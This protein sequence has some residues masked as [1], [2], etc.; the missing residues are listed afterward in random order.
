MPLIA[1]SG[2]RLI[3]A[4]GNRSLLR[5]AALPQRN[6][7]KDFLRIALVNNMP[8]AAL[9]DT[10]LQFFELLS[11]AAGDLPIQVELYSLP[12]IPRGDR[13]QAHLNQYY[14]S[15]ATLLNQSLDGMI[16]TGT[17]PRQPEL[18]DEPYWGALTDLCNW[19][20][21][22]TCS[23]VLSCL[24]AHA[25]VL[26]GDGIRR[27]PLGEKRFGV[28]EHEMVS[29]HPLTDGLVSPVRMP[30]SRWNELRRGD[31]TSAGYTVLTESPRAGVDFFVKEKKRSLFVYFQGHPEYLSLTLHK[32]YRRDV[33]RYLRRERENYPLVPEGYFDEASVRLLR[34]FQEKVEG[35]RLESAMES[36]PEDKTVESLQHTWRPASTRIYQNW[37]N[38]LLARKTRSLASSSMASVGQR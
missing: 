19:A 26:H 16:I 20:E 23:A 37:L 36:F 24:A 29:N 5:A 32:E 2:S 27:H 9:E 1:P 8:D 10:E 18:R 3:P 15:T 13:A 21:E 22:N 35:Q 12:G 17:E 25:G 28:Y 34:E 6:K 38:Y 33:K 30:H 7:P 14:K 31:L 4:A 11:A